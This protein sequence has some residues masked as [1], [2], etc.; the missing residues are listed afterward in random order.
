MPETP[1]DGQ[2]FFSKKNFGRFPRRL[3]F[4]GE[5]SIAR[6]RRNRFSP[7]RPPRFFPAKSPAGRSTFLSIR[8][9]GDAPNS[10]LR[11]HP[12]APRKNAAPRYRPTIESGSQ[13]DDRSTPPRNGSRPG[14]RFVFPPLDSHRKAVGYSRFSTS[15]STSPP[16]RI[17]LPSIPLRF[18]GKSS[19]TDT[20]RQSNLR[21]R[22][23]DHPTSPRNGF[24]LAG[25]SKFGIPQTSRQTSGR[26]RFPT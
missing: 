11:N 16:P 24:R 21:S 12:N 20:D 19:R 10:A 2:R 13:T 18:S 4:R 7:R 17:P 9:A 23:D 6:C 22:I 14:A 26:A 1:E 8:D 15:P 5:S 3:F 25:R